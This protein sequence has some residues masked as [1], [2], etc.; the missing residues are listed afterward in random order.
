[1]EEVGEADA[2]E[3]GAPM[4][5]IR[6]E[7][8]QSWTVREFVRRRDGLLDRSLLFDCGMAIRRVRDFPVAW[9]EL[10]DAELLQVSRRR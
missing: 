2:A 6:D 7:E 9:H 1:M 5:V 4:R 3:G 8:G 10:P